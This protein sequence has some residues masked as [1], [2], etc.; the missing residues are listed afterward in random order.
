MD[1]Y[2]LNGTVL[3]ISSGS[4]IKGYV[5]SQILQT[6]KKAQRADVEARTQF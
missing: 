2:V 3:E 6:L 4:M 1:S 5:I